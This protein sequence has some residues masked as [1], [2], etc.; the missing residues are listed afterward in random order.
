M[1]APEEAGDP[2]EASPEECIIQNG[3]LKNGLVAASVGAG[4]IHLWAAWA[5]YDYTREL[6]FFVMVAALQ[7]WLAAVVLWIRSI[8]WSLLIGGAAANAG[9]VVVWVL[10]R[11][12]GLPG[13]PKATHM[14]MDQI[15]ERAARSQHAKGFMVHKETFGLLDTTCSLLEIGFVVGVLMLLWM[16]RR[17]PHGESGNDATVAVGTGVAEGSGGTGSPSA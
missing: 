5:H 17:R 9:V 7:L 6:V 8:P 15:M 12:T 3:L 14:D 2:E 10:T 1:G 16:R 13:M 11:T 4:A